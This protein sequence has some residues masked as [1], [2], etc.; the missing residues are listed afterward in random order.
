MK[1]SIIKKNAPKPSEDK[2]L[3][4]GIV[5]FNKKILGERPEHFSVFLKDENDIIHGGAMVWVHTESIYID[6]LWVSEELRMQGYGTKL[7]RAAEEEAKKRRC[8]YST[9]DTYSFQ[10]EEFYLKNGYHQM[11][12]IKNYLFEHSK[13]FFRKELVELSNE[14]F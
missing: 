6:V 2:I 1:I 8:K 7:M 10:A 13:I 11:G 4:E 9:V 5:E 12:E 14:K 3:R